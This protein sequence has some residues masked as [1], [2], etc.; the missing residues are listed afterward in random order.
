M[1]APTSTASSIDAAALLLVERFH[2]AAILL[3][4]S[5]AKGTAGP[6]S[7]VDLGL[8]AGGEHPDPFELMTARTELEEW[9]GRPVDLVLLDGVSPI[10]AMEALRHHRLLHLADRTAWEAFQV[11]AMR[12]YFDLKMVRRPIEEALLRGR[13]A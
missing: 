5:H 6:A 12:E 10:L 4:G 8:L 3:Y 9:L 11:R 2:P 13:P 1:K 7:D